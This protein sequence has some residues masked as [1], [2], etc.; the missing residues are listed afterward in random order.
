MK[1]VKLIV[2]IFIL[3]FALFVQSD[4]AFAAQPSSIC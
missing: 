3:L 2:P 1:N 4:I